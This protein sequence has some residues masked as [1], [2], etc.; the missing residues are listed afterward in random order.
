M[1]EV[2]IPIEVKDQIRIVYPKS[3]PTDYIDAYVELVKEEASHQCRDTAKTRDVFNVRPRFV[4][5]FK[6]G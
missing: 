6:D 2:C 3:I 4:Q 5:L 1:C